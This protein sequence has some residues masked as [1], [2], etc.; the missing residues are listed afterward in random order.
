MT[1]EAKNEK[2]IGSLARPVT[3]APLRRSADQNDSAISRNQVL[4]VNSRILNGL[5]HVKIHSLINLNIQQPAFSC[6]FGLM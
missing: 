2:P 5:Q 1:R 6:I 3:A 4:P